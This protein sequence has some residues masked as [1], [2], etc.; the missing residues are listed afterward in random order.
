MKQELL[1]TKRFTSVH[2]RLNLQKGLLQ[3]PSAESSVRQDELGLHVQTD[4]PDC[5]SNYTLKMAFSIMKM[6]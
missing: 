3:P 2:L 1:T 6:T 4:A 5:G